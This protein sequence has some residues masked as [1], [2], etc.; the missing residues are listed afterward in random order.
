MVENNM[1]YSLPERQLT[2]YVR[3]I[4]SRECKTILLE[5]LVER[6]QDDL[7]Q[8]EIIKNTELVDVFS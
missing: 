3:R 1:N 6:V 7:A 4:Y 2:F 8:I 5:F